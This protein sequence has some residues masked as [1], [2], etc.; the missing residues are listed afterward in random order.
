M[1]TSIYFGPPGTGKTA[2][3]LEIAR[4]EISRDQR[5]AFLSFSRRAATEARDRGRSELGL[6]DD[7]LRWWGTLHST[8]ARRIGIGPDELMGAKHYRE[9]GGLIGRELTAPD[10]GGRVFGTPDR[11]GIAAQAI[12]SLARARMV[13]PV[14]VYRPGEV[15]WDE[16]ERLSRKMDE[17][18]RDRRIMDYADLLDCAPDG[19][20]VDA[21]ILDEA[22]DLTPAQWR[23]FGRVIRG[24]ERVYI[25]G[26]DDQAIYEWAGADVRAFLAVEGTRE[27][28]RTSHRL[29][30]RVYQVAARVLTRIGLR[31]PKDWVSRDDE[32]RLLDAPEP[33]RVPV[34][35]G[36]GTWLLMARTRA[37]AARWDT[38]CRDRGLVF[39]REGRSSIDPKEAEAIRAWE[40]A[41]AGRKIQGPILEGAIGMTG[42]PMELD[43]GRSYTLADVGIMDAPVWH[44]ALT[45]ISP[46]RRRYYESCLRRDPRSLSKEPTI[47]VS[48]IHGSKGAQADRVAIMTDLPPAAE[49][50]ARRDPDPEHRVWYVAATRARQSL[51]LVRP[52]GD[53]SYRYQ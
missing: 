34:D 29:P 31:Q 43:P 24:A 14:A 4:D 6:G 42:R 36:D 45:K 52:S 26:D 7:D 12:L 18:K 47:T 40:T 3:L 39:T 19:L 49:E 35:A 10:E 22:Q 46:A 9:L 51:Y 1:R 11:T 44:R 53:R 20:P 16:V 33:G 41:R 13:D 37:L 38:V 30:R 21:V 15:Q 48:T 25:A 32:G 23:Y 28:L 50:A 2:R 5:V 27:V 8:A 17:F